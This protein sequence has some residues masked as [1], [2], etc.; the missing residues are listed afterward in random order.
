MIAL[1]QSNSGTMALM[2]VITSG[3]AG[4]G[5]WPISREGHPKPLI[6]PADWKRLL[7]RAF[8]RAAAPAG[9]NEV[10]TANPTQ[11]ATTFLLK[12]FGRTTAAPVRKVQVISPSFANLQQHSRRLRR[13]QKSQCMG[14][15][16]CAINRSSIGN[17]NAMSAP[18]TATP[19]A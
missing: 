14:V 8:A 13:N 3:G 2:P 9:V 19:P 15:V 11:L 12:A 17:L 16:P 7:Q 10:Y 6:V 4:S 1:P 18:V 5:L